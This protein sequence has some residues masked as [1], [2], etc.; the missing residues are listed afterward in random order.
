MMLVLNFGGGCRN[1]HL[2]RKTTKISVRVCQVE[3]PLQ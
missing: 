1:V 2:I 3:G